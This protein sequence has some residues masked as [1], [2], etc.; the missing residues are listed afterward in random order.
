MHNA[1]F[2]ALRMEA[3]YV[4]WKVAPAQ[5]RTTIAGLRAAGASGGN[6]TIP[7]KES[8]VGW[9][10]GLAGEAALL[11]TVNT[12]VRRGGRWIGYNTDGAGF[13]RA[14]REETRFDPRGKTACLLGAGGAAKAVAYAL[15]RSGLAKLFLANRTP[16]RA[17]DLSALL[18]RHAKRLII[19]TIAWRPSAIEEAAV[20][21]HLVVNATPLERVPVRVGVLH[22]DTV[23]YDLIYHPTRLVR[24]ARRHGCVA[25]NGLG[26]LLYQGAAAF[27]LWTGRPAPIQVMRKALR[28][29]AR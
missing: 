3:V 27:E 21:S 29:A 24:E 9:L 20:E 11:R 6:V 17:R 7:H 26:M 22:R 2:R 28:K 8:V 12:I 23:I 18:A 4:P 5:L 15:A 10:D 19:R 1:A 25:A 13:V 14:L 16:A